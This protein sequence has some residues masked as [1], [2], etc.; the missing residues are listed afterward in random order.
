MTKKKKD[1][2]YK[3][4]ANLV[5]NYVCLFVIIKFTTNHAFKIFWFVTVS[6]L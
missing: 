1:V 6:K 2:D 5:R 4:I 3:I